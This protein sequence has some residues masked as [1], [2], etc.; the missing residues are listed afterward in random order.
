MCEAESRPG[1]PI[2]CGPHRAASAAAAAVGSLPSRPTVPPPL[3]G[4]S[5]LGQLTLKLEC[6]TAPSRLEYTVNAPTGPAHQSTPWLQYVP[7]VLGGGG[8]VRLSAG[9]QRVRARATAEGMLPSTTAWTVTLLPVINPLV[10]GGAAVSGSVAAGEY[11]FYNLTVPGGR[12]AETDLTLAASGFGP[13]DILAS[14]DVVRPKLYDGG[15]G[16]GAGRMWASLS[17]AG[18]GGALTLTKSDLPPV[19][20]S[21]LHIF[22]AIHGAGRTG[23]TSSGYYLSAEIDT[24]Q[25]VE[26]NRPVRTVAL[27]G[28][29]AMF[30]VR[31]TLSECSIS[32]RR[33]LCPDVRVCN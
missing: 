19:P 20:L 26:F 4:G 17:K 33:V 7:F 25:A 8:G 2:P 13:L 11:K 21:G 6:D 28:D 18:G 24:T 1:V 31:P 30:K 3:L 14:I 27:P 16:G 10:V 15:E 9:V 32:V 29:T 22:V 12:P 23:T 5:Y